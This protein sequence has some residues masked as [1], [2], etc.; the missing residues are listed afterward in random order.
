MSEHAQK[1]LFRWI[2]EHPLLKN[3]PCKDDF[4]EKIVGWG[5]T[6][7]KVSRKIRLCSV[8]ELHNDMIKTKS[9][10]G[11]DQCRDK[12]NNVI[13]SDTSLRNFIKKRMPHVKKA[14]K[15]D[16]QMC[17]CAMCVIM[18]SQHESLVYW[19]KSH[20]RLQNRK[21]QKI[22]EELLELRP[23]RASNTR[24]KQL[25]AKRKE[26]VSAYFDYYKHVHVNKHSDD[27][28]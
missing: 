17:G 10:G 16:K 22:N 19:R 18:K 1:E 11:F 20:L 12:D 28:N 4:V 8:T 26:A 5:D 3:S 6:K 13:M 21:I 25:E 23:S 24:K 9:N 14:T 15:R 27:N 2:E 7:E